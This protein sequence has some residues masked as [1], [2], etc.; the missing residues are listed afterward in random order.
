M[1]YV[2]LFQ[3]F[4]IKQTTTNELRAL[5]CARKSDKMPT[6]EI[7]NCK[8]PTK[9]TLLY[10]RRKNKLM[11]VLVSTSQPSQQRMNLPPFRPRGFAKLKPLCKSWM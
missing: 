1:Q 5:L 6:K 9:K 4:I 11:G 10:M 2:K 7:A 3:R 8:S